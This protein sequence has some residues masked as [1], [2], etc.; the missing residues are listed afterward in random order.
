VLAYWENGLRHITNN[1]KPI[2]KPEDLKGMKIR[3]PENRMTISIFKALGANPAPLTY[4]ELYLAL[5]QGVFDGQEN[6]ITN[7]HARNFTKSR[8]S[9]ATY[10][11]EG[12]PSPS[13]K[14]WKT[15]NQ[16][17]RRIRTGLKYTP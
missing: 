5:S 11:N 9:S 10:H 2:E 4:S 1:K 7:I 13:V 12:N 15:P 8:N 17:S 14:R 16:K 3:T 6:P